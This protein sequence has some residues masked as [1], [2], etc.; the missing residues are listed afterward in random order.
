VD[1]ALGWVVLG[2]VSTVTGGDG[3]GHHWK[4]NRIVLVEDPV[5]LFSFLFAMMVNGWCQ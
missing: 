5:G 4:N 2:A 3:R 1:G